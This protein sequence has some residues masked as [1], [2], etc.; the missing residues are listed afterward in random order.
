MVHQ[1]FGGTVKS[2]KPGTFCFN[3]AV[4]PIFILPCHDVAL[5]WLE[6]QGSGYIPPDAD[7]KYP[8]FT[9]PVDL[10][11]LSRGWQ[12]V[13][14]KVGEELRAVAIARRRRRVGNVEARFEVREWQPFNVRIPSKELEQ[15]PRTVTNALTRKSGLTPEQERDLVAALAHRMPWLPAA[16]AEFRSQIGPQRIPANVAG[17]LGLER[18]AFWTALSAAG[19]PMHFIADYHFRQGQRGF[20]DGVPKDHYHYPTEDEQILQ[21]WQ[22][23]TGWS[24]TPDC[25]G[26]SRTYTRGR[27]GRKLTILHVNKAGLETATGA[28]LIYMNETNNALVLIQY[29]RMA[30][31][32]AKGR[33]GY[34][35][36][37]DRLEDQLQRLQAIDDAFSVAP[38][39][40]GD[41]SAR[42]HPHPSFIKLCDGKIELDDNTAPT[43]GMVLPL[44]EFTRLRDKFTAAKIA[45][46]SRENVRH[47][48]SSTLMVDLIK[49]SWVGTRSS[50]HAMKVLGDFIE[51]RLDDG[52]ALTLATSHAV[53]PPPTGGQERAP[54]PIPQPIAGLMV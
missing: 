50:A 8:S 7:G 11:D 26:A 54:D 14:L 48:I 46:F 45:R 31:Q 3:E 37:G 17:Q 4:T 18:E 9:F 16:I 5:E 6:R 1:R 44:A 53:E 12:V 40:E 25:Y 39:A 43:P 30:H 19:Y 29:K 49:S 51:G 38:V 23:L 33:W 36:G 2:Q 22:H 35:F 42:L 28:D 41:L 20:I 24:P 15:G 32:D 10:C 27:T 34:Y 52:A 47:S 13:M 21:D